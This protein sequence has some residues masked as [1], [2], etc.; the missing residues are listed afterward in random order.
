MSLKTVL[1]LGLFQ[2]CLGMFSLLNYG[3][4]N[5][6]MV[7]EWCWNRSAARCLTWRYARP[8]FSTPI[9]WSA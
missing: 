2:F 9:R 7:I 5:R 6:V 3:L 4:L 8:P 1:R